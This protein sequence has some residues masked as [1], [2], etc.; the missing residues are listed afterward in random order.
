MRIWDALKE[1][2]ERGVWVGF[3][4]PDGY[5]RAIRYDATADVWWWR[6]KHRGEADWSGSSHYKV[7]PFALN[8]YTVST[9]WE[10]VEVGQ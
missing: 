3:T 10:I 9:E 2:I 8:G 5:Q 7:A 4:E 6:T 1:T